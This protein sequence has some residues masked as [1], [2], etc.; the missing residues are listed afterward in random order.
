MTP[1]PTTP[2][3]VILIDNVTGQPLKVSS[4]IAPLNEMEVVVTHQSWEFD[5]A[6]LGKPFNQE[7]PR[8]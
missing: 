7:V 6:A 5:E 3:I 8:S 4:N 1:P 2:K